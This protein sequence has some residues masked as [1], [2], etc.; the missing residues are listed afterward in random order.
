MRI[1]KAIGS[2]FRNTA[3]EAGSVWVSTDTTI[4]CQIWGYVSG[5]R[6]ELFVEAEEDTEVYF[7]SKSEIDK[8]CAESLELSNLLRKM[9]ESHALIIENELMIFADYADSSDRYLAIM[10]R[11]PE[12]LQRISLKKLAS[13][14]LITPQSLSRIRAGLKKINHGK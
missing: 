13:Y 5:A 11:E 8:L 3:E 7:I 9:F 10:K 1:K 2:G 6:S 12:L 14:L 4:V